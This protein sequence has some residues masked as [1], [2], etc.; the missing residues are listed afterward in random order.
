MAARL[1]KQVLEALDNGWPMFWRVGSELGV[2][3]LRAETYSWEIGTKRTRR[4]ASFTMLERAAKLDKALADKITPEN[5]L[6]AA[7]DRAYREWLKR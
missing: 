3:E 7:R 4:L 6:Q 1:P 2:F 5:R